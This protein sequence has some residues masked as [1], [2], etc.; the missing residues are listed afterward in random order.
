MNVCYWNLSFLQNFKDL[1]VKKDIIVILIGHW[2]LHAFSLIALTEWSKPN[3][4]GPLFLLVFFPSFFY[5]IT[6][7]LSDPDNFKW[8]ALLQM[9]MWQSKVSESVLLISVC[10][11]L[12]WCIITR[13]ST[14]LCMRLWVSWL[15]Q[16]MLYWKSW[17]FSVDSDFLPQGMLTRWAAGISS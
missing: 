10:I 7:R 4:D 11:S 12:Y 13:A 9:T 17:M 14:F 2:F 5:I 1:L 6:V 16:S 8:S 3:V 15:S